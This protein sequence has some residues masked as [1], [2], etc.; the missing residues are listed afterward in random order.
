MKEKRRFDLHKGVETFVEAVEA[1][2]MQGNPKK[3]MQDA[4]NPPPVCPDFARLRA[5]KIIIVWWRG[6]I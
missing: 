2:E 6:R 4:G 3:G 5:S 1:L